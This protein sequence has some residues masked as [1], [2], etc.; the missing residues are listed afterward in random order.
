MFCAP[1]ILKYPQWT[2]E[3]VRSGTK[4]TGCCELPHGCWKLNSSLLKEEQ[5][6]LTAE[7]SL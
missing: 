7:A 4:V 3:G 2:E 6:P 1:H 5:V